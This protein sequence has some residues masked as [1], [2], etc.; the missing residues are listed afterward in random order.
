MDANNGFR[1]NSWLNRDSRFLLKSPAVIGVK[2]KGKWNIT[3]PSWQCSWYGRSSAQH[4]FVISHW[5]NSCCFFSD[6]QKLSR[7]QNMRKTLFFSHK[8][9]SQPGKRIHVLVGPSQRWWTRLGKTSDWWANGETDHFCTAT[10]PPTTY[11]K[12]PGLLKP[13][14]IERHLTPIFYCS[15]FAIP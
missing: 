9:Q 7:V 10:D 13:S 6:R 11:T 12:H 3:S 15:W 8:S 4:T 5:R 1:R 2:R 14:C